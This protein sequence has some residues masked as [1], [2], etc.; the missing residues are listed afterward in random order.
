MKKKR[1]SVYWCFSECHCEDWFV[2]AR[3][4]REA[5]RFFA[6]YEDMGIEEVDVD[7]LLALPEGVTVVE[8]GW[9]DEGLLRACGAK[10][11]RTD[12]P[13]AAELKGV[14]YQEGHMNFILARRADDHF[15]A[16]GSGRPNG[17]VNPLS[18]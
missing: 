8:P 13:R 1:W 4:W 6:D 9:A 16:R 2:V 10:I 14:V 5:R 11:L 18:N 3:T 15:E 12:N 17:T 7:R